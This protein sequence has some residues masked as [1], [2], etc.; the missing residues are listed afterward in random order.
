MARQELNPEESASLNQTRAL[1]EHIAQN[2]WPFPGR[3]LENVTLAGLVLNAPAEVVD[4]GFTSVIFDSPSWRGARF[5]G[6]DFRSCRTRSASLNQVLFER[7]SLDAANFTES[8]ITS[9]RFNG[10]S[11]SSSTFTDSRFDQCEFDGVAIEIGVFESCEFDACTFNNCQLLESGFTKIVPRDLVIR[12]GRMEM[13]TLSVAGGTRLT[14][15]SCE[16]AD[17]GLNIEQLNRLEVKG[18]T[19]SGVSIEGFRCGNISVSECRNLAGFRFLDG[20]VGELS[21]SN[22]RPLVDSGIDNVKIEKLNLLEMAAVYFRFSDTTISGGR[23]AASGFLGLEFSGCQLTDVLFDDVE[24]SE[25]LT[26]SNCR[27]QRLKLN[28]I[29]Y[30]PDTKIS[31]QQNEYLQ[32]ARFADGA[33]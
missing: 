15:E 19:G 21:M 6:V 32:S 8:R 14:L 30:Q 33:V 23:I 9:T 3:Q 29:A 31:Q 26:L 2:G 18:C 27:F 1:N 17:N 25:S 5:V 24:F 10:G 20:E 16:F 7:C 4:V 13:C 28:N 22:C 11:I 12:G